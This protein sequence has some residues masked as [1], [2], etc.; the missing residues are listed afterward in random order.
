M[1]ITLNGEKREAPDH[2]TI[3]GLL[4]YLN[5]QPG[6]VAVELNMEIVKKDNYSSVPV[7]DGDSVEVVSFMGGGCC[8]EEQRRLR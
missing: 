7:K 5:I 6:R 8:G 4:E 1:T 3:R 2:V